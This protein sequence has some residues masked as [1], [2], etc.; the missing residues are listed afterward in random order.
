MADKKNNKGTVILKLDENKLVLSGTLSAF[1]FGT[2]KFDKETERYFVSIKADDIPADVRKTIRETYFSDTKEKYIP[3]PFRE[4]ADLTNT[5][6]NLKSQYEIPV[7]KEGS[8]NKKYTFQ[9]V[10]DLGDGLP[11][12]GSEVLLSCRLKEGAVY[13]LAVKLIT[14]VKASADDFFA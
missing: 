9:E 13:P 14:I 10:I 6:I 1:R 5:Y 3:E 7:F 11:P 8:G 2:N 12:Y 4:G